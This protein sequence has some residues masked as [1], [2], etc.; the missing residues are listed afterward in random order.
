MKRYRLSEIPLLTRVT[1]VC[2]AGIA[3]SYIPLLILGFFN[4]PSNDDFVFGLATVRAWRENGSLPSLVPAAVDTT[5]QVYQQWQGSFAAVFLFTLQ[6]AIFGEDGYALCAPFLLGSLTIGHLL[7]SHALFVH[8]LRCSKRVLLLASL[9]ILFCS[10][11]FMPSPAQGIY[12]WNGAIYYTF[13]YSLSLILLSLVMRGGRPGGRLRA[14]VLV[15]SCLL[16]FLVGGGNYVTALLCSLILGLAAVY[17]L[18]Q[19]NSNLTLISICSLF[20]LLVAFVLS[21]VSPGNGVRAACYPGRLGPVETI[22]KS[23]CYAGHYLLEWANPAVLICL[24]CVALLLLVFERSNLQF[25]YPL[26]VLLLSFCL[27]SAQFT[28]PCYAMGTEGEQR[29]TDIIYYSFL[30]FTVLNLFY[31]GGWLKRKL[32]SRGCTTFPRKALHWCRQHPAVCSL[33]AV[34][35]FL[36]SLSVETPTSLSA[37]RSLSSGQAAQYQMEFNERLAVLNDPSNQNPEFSPYTSVPELLLY[38]GLTDDPDYEWSNRPMA[39]YYE[40]QSIRL[41]KTE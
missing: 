14:P 27:F 4:H 20:C 13:F 8:W 3:L 41:K 32:S 23:F 11:Q 26:V 2:V 22:Q 21:A 34:T 25:R 1:V 40:K 36:L 30:W 38:G 39:Q 18:I 29:I 5:A 12:W 6:P 7:F 15:G 9:P 19:K 17:G 28:P 10:V 35:C 31:C 24:V 16:G 33:I 37:I